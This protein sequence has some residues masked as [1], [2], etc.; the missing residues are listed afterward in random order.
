[1]QNGALNAVRA[2]E[3]GQQR[4]EDGVTQVTEA[5][6]MLQQITRA[7]ESIRDMNR[8]IATAAEEQTSVAE[9]IS[10]NLTEITAI[11]HSNQ[12]TVQRTHAASQVLGDL[13]Q[14]LGLV[15]A[16]LQM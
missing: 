12:D 7:V 14:Q 10:Q 11:A 5:G 13:S 16:R 8:Q 6:A 2:I 3:G 1:M 15:S 4:S 9:D